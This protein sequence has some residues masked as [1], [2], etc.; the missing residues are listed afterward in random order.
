MEW[1]IKL[2][3]F[4]EQ[5]LI[6]NFVREGG[7]LAQKNFVEARSAEKNF[8]GSSSGVWGHAPAANF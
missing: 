1:Q 5:A 4:L 8:G 6:Q 2:Y 7:W 3:V